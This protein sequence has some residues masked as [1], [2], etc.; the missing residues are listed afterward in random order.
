MQGKAL[1]GQPP[2]ALDDSPVSCVA[3]G[4]RLLFC[5]VQLEF[6][7]AYHRLCGK[8]VLFGQGF[9]CTGM[10]IKVGSSRGAQGAGYMCGWQGL[11]RRGGSCC[12]WWGG[13]I[14]GGL[15]A[16]HHAIMWCLSTVL[17]T[18]ALHG[19]S[20]CR[21]VLHRYSTVFQ[22]LCVQKQSAAVDCSPCLF[23]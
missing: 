2:N 16:A 6:A 17:W 22:E 7:A 9:H 11:R 12:H 3:T 5:C 23:W 4:C 19:S 15:A 8:R 14:N 10:P 21:Y 20:G 1:P 13:S 18:P